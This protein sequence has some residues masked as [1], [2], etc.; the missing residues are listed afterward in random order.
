[1]STRSD[2][3]LNTL[4]QLATFWDMEPSEVIADGLTWRELL[5]AAECAGADVHW[6]SWSDAELDSLAEAS[7]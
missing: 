4:S 1:M 5:H 3:Y 2:K 6:A 7:A